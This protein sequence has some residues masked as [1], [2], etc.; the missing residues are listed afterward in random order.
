VLL[1]ET[2]VAGNHLS[3]ITW[4]RFEFEDLETERLQQTLT[5][6]DHNRIGQKVVYGCE[7]I[8]RGNDPKSGVLLTEL[9]QPLYRSLSDDE[10]GRLDYDFSFCI[11]PDL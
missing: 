4:H 1:D 6:L 5:M 8:G 9:L 7:A 3:N 10:V 11:E 2:I